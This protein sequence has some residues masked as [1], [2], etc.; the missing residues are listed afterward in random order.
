MFLKKATK[1]H[2][3]LILSHSLKYMNPKI[4]KKN[5][6]KLVELVP[7]FSSLSHFHSTSKKK[8]KTK[9]KVVDDYYTTRKEI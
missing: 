2:Y 8:K 7:P 5:N 3:L 9:K 1:H 6:I 4:K